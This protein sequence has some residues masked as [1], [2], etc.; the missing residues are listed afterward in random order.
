[1][2]KMKTKF[3][4]IL[5]ILSIGVF[6]VGCN[7][8][9][10]VTTKKNN[11]SNP[12]T[13]KEA[14]PPTIPEFTSNKHFV[15]GN[16]GTPPQ[17]N[18]GYMEYANNPNYC[19][20]EEWTKF[21]DCG[22]TVAVPGGGST[23][24]SITRDLDMASKVG[25]KVLVRD[26]TSYS[27]E[28]II[29]KAYTKGYD[30]KQTRAE[31]SEREESLKAQ[32]DIFKEYDSFIGIT[33]I[34]EPSTEYYEII[35]ACQ[36]W[37]YLNYPDYLFYVNLLPVYATPTQLYGKTGPGNSYTDYVSLFAKTVNPYCLSYDHY[38][39]LSDYDGSP[40]IKEDFLYNLN[41][42]AIQAKKAKVP[43]YLYI[44]T[45]GFFSNLPITTYEEFAWQVYTS[46]AFGAQGI[47]CFQYWTQLQAEYHNNVRHGIV[48]R[49]GTINEIYYEVQK[50]FNNLKDIENI[51]LSYTW[52][53]VKT[54]EGGR[55]I[56]DSFQLVSNQLEEL[57]TIKDVKTDSDIIIGQFVKDDTYAFMVTN[58]T[59]PFEPVNANVEL[60]FDGYDYC[61][62]VEQ[63][64]KTL[65]KLTNH[66]LTYEVKS[67]EGIFVIPLK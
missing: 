63:N 2:R 44:Q 57:E 55:I 14:T 13:T 67:G 6:M 7:E 43:V 42:F 47:F 27:I 15:F 58:A 46:L 53:G 39:F 37:F 41:E 35:A 23:I 11:N 56:N 66:V 33:A 8:N 28:S 12:T 36:D 1:M 20:V 32:I 51:Y 52:D 65:V 16:W 10:T 60:T 30:Y 54:F 24:E 64:T 4:N 50:V 34:D 26:R 38:S 19:T 49:D 22:F 31:L 29:N 45:M 17:E 40:Y 9:T 5:L 21:K 25:M 3:L 62:V 18:T 61:Y 59:M 48:E